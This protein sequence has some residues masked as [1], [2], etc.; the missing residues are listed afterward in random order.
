M[1]V[2]R[3]AEHLGVSDRMV[4]KW[5]AGGEG[6]RP[7]PLNQEA[8]DTSLAM[9][10]PEEKRRFADLVGGRV[11]PGRPTRIE[12]STRS[13]YHVVRHPV[14][15]KLMTMIDPG[16]FRVGAGRKPQWLPGFY[17]DVH[18]TS[19]AD[20]ARFLAATGH[21][22][23]THWPGGTYVI[24]DQADALHDDPVTGLGQNDARAYARWASKELPTAVQWD[25]AVRGAEGFVTAEVWEWCH[26]DTRR[27]RH[28]PRCESGGGFR[29][30]TP[31]LEMLALLAI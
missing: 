2:R 20:Y 16:P 18:P 25:R 28:G 9:A 24:T 19:H 6:I 31:T 13:A 12:A 7:R 11:P 4:S 30:A 21:P 17:I 27:A 23:P 1:S 3:F 22:P 5:E 26:V 8:L 10:S 29:C 14:D 15:G